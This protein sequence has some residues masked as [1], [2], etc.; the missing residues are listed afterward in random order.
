MICGLNQV[1]IEISFEEFL[2]LI[3]GI[4]CNYYE[5]IQNNALQHK[6]HHS[7]GHGHE[8]SAHSYGQSQET[9]L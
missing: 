9:I 7:H 3:G 2:I 5:K 4:A 8:E 6:H 1:E